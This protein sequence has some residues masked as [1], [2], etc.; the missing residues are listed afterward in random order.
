MRGVVSMTCAVCGLTS[1]NICMKH[2]YKGFLTTTSQIQH[3]SQIDQ[4]KSCSAQP[5][6]LHDRTTSMMTIGAEATASETHLWPKT[7]ATL[8][9]TKPRVTTCTCARKQSR[10]VLL[11]HSPFAAFASY[12]LACLNVHITAP[13]R[14]HA[15]A[16]VH[17][18]LPQVRSLVWG[19][20]AAG[21]QK[22]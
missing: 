12:H 11:A 3:S 17:M 4:K 1:L 2:L 6:N 18:I 14:Q 5:Y 22:G 8:D 16:I 10:L 13:D 7:D 15:S 20:P 21:S 19:P 9:E